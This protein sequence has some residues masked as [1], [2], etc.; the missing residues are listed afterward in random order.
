[1]SDDEIR[2]L[3][4]PLWLDFRGADCFPNARPLLA[5]Y[6]SVR[7]LESILQTNGVWF[8]HPLL[9]SDP[10]E[11]KF[12]LMTGA[13]LFF[14]SE[15]M[16]AA[17]GSQAR[18]DRLRGTF[19][20]WF[21]TFWEE[22]LPN[23]FMVCFCEHAPDDYDGVL[24]MWREYA[25][26]GNGV[27]VVIDTGRIIPR[28]DS[29]FIVSK[30]CYSSPDELKIR[31][32][33]LLGRCA[34]IIANNVIPDDKLVVCS[35]FIFQ[36]L[37]TLAMFTKHR[38][39]REENE[40][41]IVYMRDMGESEMLNHMIGSSIVNGQAVPK[42]KLKIAAFAGLPETANLGLSEL[43]ERI[44]LGPASSQL[45]AAGCAKLLEAHGCPVLKDRLRVSEIPYPE[46][47]AGG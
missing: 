33:E 13:Q 26:R 39:Y 1:M 5:H 15:R 19:N 35:F 10:K 22:H 34:D 9:M 36:R 32:D 31:I 24:S 29:F 3:F 21:K 17:C 43:V 27:A 23:T 7:V 47:R 38:G 44:L 12:G 4:V 6:T 41:R 14:N 20:A 2:D 45:A 16:R 37:K 25:D 46:L 42:L 40:W 11:L 18:F 28:E 8:S 30:I